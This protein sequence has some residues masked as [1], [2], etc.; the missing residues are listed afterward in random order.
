MEKDKDG[1]ED[2]DLEFKEM[3]QVSKSLKDMIE[4]PGGPPVK[5]ANSMMPQN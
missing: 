4:T 3:Q 1:Y 2:S 5:H